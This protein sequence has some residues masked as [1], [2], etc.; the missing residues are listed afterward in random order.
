MYLGDTLVSIA[1]GVYVFGHEYRIRGPYSIWIS[2]ICHPK[3]SG[4]FHLSGGYI[5]ILYIYNDYIWANYNDQTLFS[6]T[7]IMVNEGNPPKMALSVRLW[8]I[9]ICPDYI[10]WGYSYKSIL[11]G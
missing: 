4:G 10:K 2:H 8:I 5:Y 1:L 11:D 9:V 6:L 7:G 3:Y